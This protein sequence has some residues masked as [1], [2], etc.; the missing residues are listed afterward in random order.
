LRIGY[1]TL[2]ETPMVP[3]DRATDWEA[4]SA[5]LGFEEQLL[6]WAWRRIVTGRNG[7]PLIAREFSKLCG[8]DAAEVL[9][10]FSTFLWALTH[11]G[12]R[13]L[14]VGY[15][16][17]PELTGDERQCLTLIAAA[18]AN[19]KTCFEANLRWL[20]CAELRPVLAIAARA[21]GTALKVHG[22]QLTLPSA[23]VPIFGRR[24][25]AGAN[26]RNGR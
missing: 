9:A 19:S 2:K 11:V 15:P 1:P 25:T 14:Q 17:Y 20:A 18:Q 5:G 3:G 4:R 16:G 21:L 24:Q 10:T 7:C 23:V 6:T 12:R 26:S 22:L 8:E 13:R